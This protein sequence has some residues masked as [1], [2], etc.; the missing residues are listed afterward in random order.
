MFETLKRMICK[1]PILIHMDPEK[2]FQMETDASNYAYRAILSQKGE[3]AKHHPVA[4]YSKSMNPAEW[5]YGI[6]DKEALAIIR[7]LQHWRHWLE[8]TKEP[9]HI[10]TDH[11]NLEYFKNPCALNCRQLCWLEQLMHYNYKIA[12]QPG[13]KNSA[14]DALLWKEEHKPHQPEE[15]APM[16]L[17]AP[18]QFIKAAWI[19]A[20]LESNKASLTL[21]D[22]Q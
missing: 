14:A 7:G 8:G 22:D 19:A 4:F 10:I 5:N 11:C 9:I 15:E 18:E 3:D 21:T 17:F 13:D 6:S 16:T 2:K 20:I 12:Y 1:S